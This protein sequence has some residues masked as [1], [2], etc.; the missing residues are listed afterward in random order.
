MK[1]FNK[2]SNRILR[3]LNCSLTFGRRE[4][5][6]SQMQF[7]W[8]PGHHIFTF[9]SFFRSAQSSADTGKEYRSPEYRWRKRR[10]PGLRHQGK[11]K[12]LQSRVDAQRKFFF[13]LLEHNVSFLCLFVCSKTRWVL[14]CRHWESHTGWKFR[15]RGTRRF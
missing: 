5:K 7:L 10:L 11:P 6:L 8:S 3:L 9:N 14:F 15:V 1:L 2:I 4:T 12:S 13:L